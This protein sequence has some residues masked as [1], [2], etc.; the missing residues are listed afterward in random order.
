MSSLRFLVSVSLAPAHGCL[1]GVF[2]KQASTIVQVFCSTRQFVHIEGPSDKGLWSARGG[3]IR[4]GVGAGAMADINAGLNPAGS[5][6]YGA[7]TSKS[8]TS[9]VFNTSGDDAAQE[10]WVVF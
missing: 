5:A 3:A 4:V 6:P 2:G 1:S 10:V 7:G 8:T 9:R